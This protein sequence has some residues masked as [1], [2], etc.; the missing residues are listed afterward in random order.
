MARIRYEF[1]NARRGVEILAAAGRYYPSKTLFSKP[2][3]T[4]ISLEFDENGV[5]FNLENYPNLYFYVHSLQFNDPAEAVY[6][7]GLSQREGKAN[8]K[9]MFYPSI[10]RL[11]PDKLVGEISTEERSIE[12]IIENG[13]LSSL[14]TWT[15]RLED[16]AIFFSL[17]GNIATATN[18]ME[19]FDK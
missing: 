7:H 19:A 17:I 8:F 4:G 18:K 15:Q 10:L 3:E 5:Q 6:W 16:S 13:N 12:V 14:R 2:V 1:E 9:G 11:T